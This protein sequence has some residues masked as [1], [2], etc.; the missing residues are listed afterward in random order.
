MSGRADKA[1]TSRGS[2]L[3]GIEMTSLR[4]AVIDFILKGPEVVLTF[5]GL[6]TVAWLVLLVW[7]LSGLIVLL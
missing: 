2:V 4:T 3:R 7:A 6:L 1:C 5:A